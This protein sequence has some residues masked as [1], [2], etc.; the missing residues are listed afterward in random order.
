MQT[1]QHL[2]ITANSISPYV[3]LPG[4]PGRVSFIASYLKNPQIISQ[5]RE[6]L[7]ASGVYKSI[8]ITICSTGIGCPS[9]AIAT[10]ELI[11]AGARVFIRVGTCG[12]SWRSDIP[13]GSLVIPIASI[14]D[15][16]TT[17]EYIPEGFPAVADPD[18]VAALRSSART[19]NVKTFVGINRTHDA[20]FGNQ[21]S[22]A[23]WGSYLCDERFD[24]KETPILSSEMECAALF[25]IASLR[26]VRAG[27]VLAVNANPEPLSPRLVGKQQQVVAETS[28]Q[29][30]KETVDKAIRV[31]LEAI[32]SINIE[33]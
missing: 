10:E 4:D 17:K 26:G 21:M 33:P 7:I 22:K 18:V 30:T 8:N 16:G 20:F 32:R 24:G 13:A 31:A 5:N 6:F 14:R 3:L 27:A 12:G 23:K 29:I 28:K 9:T 1:Q 19:L 15:E 2:I 25:V 11:N